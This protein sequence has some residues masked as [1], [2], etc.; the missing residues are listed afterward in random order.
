MDDVLFDVL[1]GLDIRDEAEIR[2]D[3]RLFGQAEPEMKLQGAPHPGG[4]MVLMEDISRT[5]WFLFA[6]MK[7]PSVERAGAQVAVEA[8]AYL[9]ALGHR[10]V[11][12]FHDPGEI[13]NQRSLD[14]RA[15][16]L[17]VFLR[18]RRQRW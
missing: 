10:G 7:V 2:L 5:R 16:I 4:F 12:K 6:S 17:R 13:R 8:H 18:K 1:I 9:A 3:L 14:D 15:T 11:E